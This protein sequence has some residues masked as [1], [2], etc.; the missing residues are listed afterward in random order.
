MIAQEK[1]ALVR[2]S[3]LLVRKLFPEVLPEFACLP[4]ACALQVLLAK[5]GQ[6]TMLQAGT[7]QWPYLRLEDDDGVR[8]THFSYFWEGPESPV[9]R[10]RLKRNL[11]P[12]IHCWLAHQEPDTVIDST[13]GTWPARARV[14]GFQWTARLPPDYLWATEREL[15]DL[16]L[17]YGYEVTYAP[18]LDACKIADACAKRNGIYEAIMEEV[19]RT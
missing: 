16:S 1:T 18:S 15:R 6:C 12:E 7:A 9:N 8:P 3:R 11:L 10:E 17:S 4:H 5:A 13:T 14:G 19:Q 2:E